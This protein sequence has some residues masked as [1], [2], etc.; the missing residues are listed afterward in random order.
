MLK[1]EPQV[2][3]NRIV[4]SLKLDKRSTICLSLKKITQVKV[5]ILFK[6]V[7]V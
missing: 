5:N 3:A 6:S 4:I 2:S 1:F 7:Q